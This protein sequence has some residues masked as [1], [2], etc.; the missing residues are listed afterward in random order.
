MSTT[1]GAATWTNNESVAKPVM[2][3]IVG[4]MSAVYAP[5]DQVLPPF[6]VLYNLN[7]AGRVDIGGTTYV[8]L[9]SNHN[10]FG[11]IDSTPGA[12]PGGPGVPG[13]VDEKLGK[14]QDEPYGVFRRPLEITD[15]DRTWVKYPKVSDFV[16]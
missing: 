4:E 16:F 1:G 8:V 6:K 12:P 11:S 5:E 15:E 3:D 14:Y 13:W 10:D 2:F 9:L 7:S